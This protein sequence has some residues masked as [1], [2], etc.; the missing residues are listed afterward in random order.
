MFYN[1]NGTLEKKNQNKEH[2]TITDIGYR[3]TKFI[4]EKSDPL[5]NQYYQ[6]EKKAK[7]LDRLDNIY[8]KDTNIGIN[9]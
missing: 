2:F 4:D 8:K 1:A 3:D 9:F 5:Y 6:D 7:S